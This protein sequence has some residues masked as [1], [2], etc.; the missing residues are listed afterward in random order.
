VSPLLIFFT[1]TDPHTLEGRP[2]TRIF[3][4]AIVAISVLLAIQ[5][6]SR[7]TLHPNIICLV[8]YLAFAGASVLWASFSPERSF[9]RYLQQA[10]VVT[11]IVLPAMLATRTVDIMRAVFL[12][13]AFA[14][15]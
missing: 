4:P 1:Y 13:F 6:R 2:E 5:N 12:C 15:I 10:I 7:L 11:S 14:L 8:A 3:W 9:V